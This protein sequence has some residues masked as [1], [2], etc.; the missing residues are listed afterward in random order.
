MPG[1]LNDTKRFIGFLFGFELLH[2]MLFKDEGGSAPLRCCSRTSQQHEVEAH[3]ADAWA[4]LAGGRR[5]VVLLP[6]R[7]RWQAACLNMPVRRVAKRGR[8]GDE[9]VFRRD[10][11]ID[12]EGRRGGR[13][14]FS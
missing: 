12:R 4:V 6:V 10:E 14:G 8:E 13:G 2:A 11:M 7:R 1:W 3:D 5:T 9:V